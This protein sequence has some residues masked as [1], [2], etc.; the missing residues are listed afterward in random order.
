VRRF[1]KVL[2][3]I[4]KR[5]FLLTSILCGVLIGVL[6]LFYIYTFTV[7]RGRGE[8]LG[9]VFFNESLATFGE[10]SNQWTMTLHRD[11]NIYAAWAD[12]RGWDDITVCTL[13]ITRIPINAVVPT[14]TD[15]YCSRSPFSTDIRPVGIYSVNFSLYLFYCE[16][17]QI[18]GC[19]DHTTRVKRYIDD[20][21][22]IA[23]QEIGSITGVGTDHQ[24]V[25]LTGFVHF[26]KGHTGI[27]IGLNPEFMYAL[28]ASTTGPDSP[29]YMGRGRY[30]GE[31]GSWIWE[32]L[33]G[34]SWDSFS[35]KTPIT[36]TITG[37][38]NN[39]ASIAYNQLLNKYFLS[40]FTGINGN[41]HVMLADQIG[42]PYSE[43]YSG[44]MEVDDINKS[45]VQIIPGSFST[46][47]GRNM[48]YMFSGGAEWD[49]L[50]LIQASI[51]DDI[52]PTFVC[53][54]SENCLS[55]SPLS[56]TPPATTISPPLPPI[57]F[58]ITPTDTITP[59]LTPTITPTP[60]PTLTPTVTPTPTVTL[61]P[62]VTP[63][64]SIT[65]T[66]SPTLT[67]TVTLTPTPPFGSPGPG[68]ESKNLLQILFDFI[69]KLIEIILSRFRV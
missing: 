65:L 2:D 46:R 17:G 66:P 53:A 10:G 15:V 45:H 37:L 69:A 67:P 21:E 9:M 22:A 52:L 11:G 33:N 57:T 55:Y 32:W 62:T 49:R 44:N 43:I 7:H 40:Y 16:F 61:T 42:G 20:G 36:Q 50:G 51:T 5:P 19:G 24:G 12:G 29:L 1:R 23:F 60:S 18:P 64:P 59:T 30:D 25:R 41:L 27:P 3:K 28:F 56:V 48:W 8:G 68:G 26:D 31:Q 39:N 13:G 34:S 35:E 47:G 63:T 4:K 38:G 58:I 6:F 54:G 14:G